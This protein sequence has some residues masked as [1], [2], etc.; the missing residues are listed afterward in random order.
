M[1][2][3]LGG[4]RPRPPRSRDVGGA[5]VAEAGPV[6]GFAVTAAAAAAIA[7]TTAIIIIVVAVIALAAVTEAGDIHHNPRRMEIL[8][9]SQ[10]ALTVNR[11]RNVHVY[12][13]NSTRRCD[14]ILKKG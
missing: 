14:L 5:E 13:R 1:E 11:D 10:H 2:C 3:P 7:V 12:R 9:D 6:V 8:P 4:G